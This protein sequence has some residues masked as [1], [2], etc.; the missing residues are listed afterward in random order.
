MTLAQNPTNTPVMRG[1]EDQIR[2]AV[3]A[4]QTVT[5]MVN[6]IYDG[7]TAIPRAIT[8]NAEGSGGFRLSVSV[9]NAAE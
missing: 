9:L 6:P 1:F 7:N 4:G 8:M 3:E 5:V 2:A